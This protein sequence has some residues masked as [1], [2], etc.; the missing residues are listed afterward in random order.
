M[1]TYKIAIGADAA[2]IEYKDALIAI[3]TSDERIESVLNIHPQGEENYPGVAFRAASLIQENVIDRAIL[4][5]GTGI[6]MAISANKVKG[7]RASTAHDSYSVERLALSN[8]AHI[9]CFGQRVIGVELAKKLAVEWFDYEFVNTTNSAKKIAEI[10]NFE[11][12]C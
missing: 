9:L 2:G 3:L 12:R 10:S 8:D 4:I 7:I 5:C 11:E 1:K 6:G